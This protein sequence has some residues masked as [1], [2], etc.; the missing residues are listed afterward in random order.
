MGLLQRIRAGGKPP[1]Q[2]NAEPLSVAGRGHVDGFLQLDELNARL[3]GR[4]GLEVFDRMAKT[5]GDVSQV[6]RLVV[7]PIVAGTWEINPDGGPEATQ[8]QLDDAEFVRWA[9][10]E[11]MSPNF[12][13]HLMECLP[14]LF[15]SGFSP[16]E[17]VW[18]TTDYKGELVTV[19]RSLQLRL[20]RTIYRWKQDEWGGLE[21]IEQYL[22]VPRAQ[23]IAGPNVA[24]VGD[25]VLTGPDDN[26]T[27]IDNPDIQDQSV[28]TDTRMPDYRQTVWL[29]MSNLLYYRV[30]AEGD[31]WEG[32]SMLRPAYKH[33]L[34][35][36]SIERM[37]A[38]AQEREALG[39]PVCYPPLGATPDQFDAMETI[40]TNIRSNSQGYVL[41]PGPKASGT[42]GTGANVGTGWLLEYLETGP[43]GTGRDP[44]PSL[45]YHTNKIAA[46]FIAEFL[47]TGTALTG[48][49]S[50]REAPFEQDPFLLSVEGFVGLIEEI[51]NDQLV[52]PIVAY[53]RPNAVA[54]PRLRMSLVD[55]TT[56]SELADFILKLT[57]VGALL[58]DK[59]LEDFVRARA[60]LPPRDPEVVQ[61]RGD[62]DDSLRREILMG[63][64]GSGGAPDGTN[65]PAGS[66]TGGSASGTKGTD[67][68]TKAGSGG[69]S[70]STA[71]PAPAGPTSAH[72]ALTRRALK[73][74]S[75][76]KLSADD[77]M[78]P[79]TPGSERVRWR[80][81]AFYELGVDLD[82][83][84]D[85]L[86]GS[87]QRVIDAGSIHVHGHAR[88][89]AAEYPKRTTDHLTLQAEIGKCLEDSYN[90]GAQT[91]S[92]EIEKKSAG[93]AYQLSA[94]TN[95]GSVADR[96]AHA[97][98]EVLD[99]MHHAV[100][101]IHLGGGSAGEKQR[102]AERAGV[103]AL[104]HT[105]RTHVT[106]AFNQGRN[107]RM[108]DAL[109]DPGE[110][111]PRWGFVY[112]AILDS[113]TCD[114][115]READ[116]GVIREL[117][118]PVLEENMPPNPHCD[119]TASGRGNQ[120]R[121]FLIPE[122][123]PE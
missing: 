56:I 71:K 99:A 47:R 90:Y 78:P 120:C 118:D 58:P 23:V 104:K 36:D 39:L 74:N 105:G 22:P 93:S 83:I 115:C 38:I 6:I 62:L 67:N 101:H 61:E 65:A 111:I 92:D 28:V 16:F 60:D 100:A 95:R 2:P 40:L 119:S 63:K 29:P 5:D 11:N 88:K 122:R 19:P 57:Q 14:V 121:C 75:T 96:A 64:N 52:A 112:T 17:K 113:N 25:P 10:F 106:A 35:K 81:Q 66:S 50:G 30:N 73:N 45:Q 110:G 20:P 9:L 98:T 107:E 48:G 94:F 89:V 53:N 7:N 116:D 86:D 24:K 42:G 13:G 15:R 87:P 103:T 72:E 33:W 69:A 27:T 1:V 54:P 70:T 34:F 31:N 32:M 46:A 18:E 4:D 108:L 102:A 114:H 97:T 3:A 21:A 91:V 68:K 59:T 77:E 41:M 55:A 43:H 51:V 85:H 80:P 49:A 82:G 117:N 79:Y 12:R 84:E 8:E 76:V 37:D 26:Q 123:M 44:Q 109:G